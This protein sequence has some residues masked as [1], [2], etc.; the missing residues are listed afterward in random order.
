[1]RKVI[2]QPDPGTIRAVGHC[3]QYSIQFW[4]CYMTSHKFTFCSMYDIWGSIP[5]LSLESIKEMSDII[6]DRFGYLL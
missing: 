5:K 4:H 3:E 2:K 1:M 6:G